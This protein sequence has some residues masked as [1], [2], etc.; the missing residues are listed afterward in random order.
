MI[1]YRA[2]NRR[3][4][5][6]RTVEAATR[7]LKILADPTRLR[8]VGALGAGPA[9]VHELCAHLAMSQPAVSHQLRHLREAGVVRARRSGREMVYALASP[10]MLAL[11]EQAAQLERKG[12]R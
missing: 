5:D 8:L 11:I 4:F 10:G 2:R 6:G 9:C 7:L 1:A 12:A 3:G